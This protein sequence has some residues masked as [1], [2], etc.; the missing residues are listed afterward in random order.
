MTLRRLRWLLL[1]LS[2]AA[3]LVVMV[4]PPRTLPESFTLFGALLGYGGVRWQQSVRDEHR[5]SVWRA[6]ERLREAIGAREH[7]AADVRASRAA[8]AI[9]SAREPVVVV[10]DGDVPEAAARA[11]LDAAER[12]LALV[13]RAGV[14]GVPV[15]VALHTRVPLEVTGW[16]RSETLRNR[17]QY[18]GGGTHVCIVD[19]VFPVKGE[20]G[21]DRFDV[22]QGL[23]G[24]VLGRCVLYAR[25][26]LPGPEVRRWAGLDARWAE[27]WSWWYGEVGMFVPQR[28]PPD[29]LLFRPEY[30]GSVPWAELACFRGV[31][32]HC[33]ALAGLASTSVPGRA[34]EF[35]YYGWG[36]QR[37]AD[38]LVADAIL[39]RGAERFVSFWTSPLRPDSAL[40]LAY[41]VPAGALARAAFSRRFVPEPT[42]QSSF[43]ELLVAAGWVVALGVLAMGLAWRREMDL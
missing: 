8:A 3:A 26:G 12:E 6:R 17:F 43:G 7:G 37:S 34:R 33:V 18:D 35:Y 24:R 13:P 16:N 36:F 9:R 15:I 21:H 14:T 23:S 20:R 1:P 19:V 29:T 27:R 22:P 11:W 39:N 5:W 38:G 30:F 2:A 10:R 42:A 31:D 40:H 25:Y 41:G 28:L 32:A 4:L